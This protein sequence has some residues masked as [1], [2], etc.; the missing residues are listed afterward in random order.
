VAPLV[1]P[2]EALL[3]KDGSTINT[4]LSGL[5]TPPNASV[6][7]EINAAVAD[8]Q[9]NI[10]SIVSLAQVKDPG[11]AGKVQ[12]WAQLIGAFFSDAAA[13][14]VN[15]SPASAELLPA[16]FGFHIPGV[17]LMAMDGTPLQSTPQAAQGIP[18]AT[19]KP[20][21][22]RGLRHAVKS[23]YTA[24]SVAE[25]WNKI[26]GAKGPHL[27]APRRRLFGFIPMPFTAV[28]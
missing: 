28:K 13:F 22:S 9:Q 7:Q 27:T 26:A 24:R 10:A 8:A 6:L 25:R 1:A 14:V 16:V 11:S 15:N 12:D 19:K 17:D 5:K 20:T 2:A 21:A 18:P 23:G 3:A 4:L